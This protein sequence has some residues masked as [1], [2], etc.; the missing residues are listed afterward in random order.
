MLVMLPAALRGEVVWRAA[1]STLC[2]VTL[3]R[4]LPLE[5]RP[6]AGQQCPQFGLQR[7]RKLCFQSDFRA[8]DTGPSLGLSLGVIARFPSCTD[9]PWALAGAAVAGHQGGP[10]QVAGRSRPIRPRGGLG[11]LPVRAASRYIGGRLSQ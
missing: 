9:C 1:G 5:V 2:A 4:C 10:G 11:R 8:P 3:L 7:D 6:M